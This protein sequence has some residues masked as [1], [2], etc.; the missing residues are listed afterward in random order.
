LRGVGDCS[1][2]LPRGAALESII[3]KN[4]ATIIAAA[5]RGAS[6]SPAIFVPPRVCAPPELGFNY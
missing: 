5:S 2:S 6:A 3:S 1:P 4:I